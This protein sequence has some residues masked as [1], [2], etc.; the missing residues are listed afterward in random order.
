M[1]IALTPPSSTTASSST[2]RVTQRSVVAAEWIKF[3]TVRS[4]LIAL[5]AA[6]CVLVVF[7]MLFSSLAGSDDC[8]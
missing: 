8:P 5:V 1:S 2:R 4:N 6:G 7:G 3:R